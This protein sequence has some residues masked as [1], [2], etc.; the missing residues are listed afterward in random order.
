[1]TRDIKMGL[2]LAPAPSDPS[3]SDYDELHDILADC[4]LAN[5]LGYSGIWTQ[6]HHATVYH[7]L[8][9]TLLFLSHVARSCPNIDLGSA[10]I[11]L[12]WH[13][14]VRLA[15][16]LTMLAGLTK[17]DLHIGCGRGTS[18]HEYYAMGIDMA[19]ARERFDETLEILNLALTGEPFT[20]EGKFHSYPRPITIHPN[21]A[22]RNITL[23]GAVGS[24]PSAQLMAE[25]AIPPIFTSG[26]PKRMLGEMLGGWKS[27]MQS[28]GKNSDVDFNVQ[29]QIL[30][31]DTDEEAYALGRRYFPLF[32]QKMLEHYEVEKS[33]CVGVEGYE[34]FER[35]F[36]T[37]RRWGTEPGAIDQYLDRNFVGSP[38]TIGRRMQEFID[39]GFNSFGFTPHV[40][41]VP[42]ALRRDTMV[43]FAKEVA[44]AFSSSFRPRTPE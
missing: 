26:F 7:Q 27:H 15:G 16:E 21:P 5:Q 25:R 38:E 34:D 3:T 12:P 6:E 41:G 10:C 28:V 35:V 33:A 2:S 20:Y 1:M 18:R 14:P 37:Y 23:Y 24:I 29:G 36:A 44:P 4:V 9:G 43:R 30:V 40:F 8:P 19:E 13:N 32:F 39:L 22:G 31:A 17:A 11:I 42:K